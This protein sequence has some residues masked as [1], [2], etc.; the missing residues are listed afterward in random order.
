MNCRLFHGRLLFR[1]N[2]CHF[3][4]AVRNSVR[5]KLRTSSITRTGVF[6]SVET[7]ECD[8]SKVSTTISRLYCTS[9]P[10]AFDYHS[11]ADS[12]LE[13][14]QDVLE[15]LVESDMTELGASSDITFSDGVLTAR[16]GRFGTYVINKQSPNRQIWLSSPKSGP[17]RYDYVNGRWIY[18]HDGVELYIL[19]SEE[20]SEVFGKRVVLSD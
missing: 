5:L 10:E 9:P 4:R 14:I 13:N 20:L 7:I 1:K 15:D 6:N 19:L 11:I 12:T 2:A 8:E 18:L 16:L 3:S 17:K